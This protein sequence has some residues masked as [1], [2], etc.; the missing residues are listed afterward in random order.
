MLYVMGG[1]RLLMEWM[2]VPLFAIAMQASC[3]GA[4]GCSRAVTPAFQ[5]TATGPAPTMPP[6]CPAL[7]AAAPGSPLLLGHQQ[8]PRAG[9]EPRA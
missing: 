4:A 8:L 5:G 1:L 6:L 2:M 7:P 9:T 3:G